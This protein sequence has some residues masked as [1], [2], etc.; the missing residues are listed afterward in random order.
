MQKGPESRANTEEA[1][2][3]EAGLVDRSSSR[4]N[5]CLSA[6]PAK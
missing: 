5:T 4:Q 3:P 2:G 6:R 1:Y